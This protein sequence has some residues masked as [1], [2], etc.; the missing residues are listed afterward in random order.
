MEP[1]STSTVVVAAAYTGKKLVDTAQE[2]FLKVSRE[3]A[4]SLGGYLRDKLDERRIYKAIQIGQRAALKLDQAGVSPM[5]LPTSFIRP[6]IESASQV[7]DP[8]LHECWANLLASAA[9]DYR[10][11]H[12]SFLNTLPDFGSGD[13]IVLK[14]IVEEDVRGMYFIRPRMAVDVDD[15]I[16]FNR[17]EHSL[18]VEDETDFVPDRGDADEH[19][20]ILSNLSRLNVVS[21]GP[22][23][24]A[25][26]SYKEKQVV[27]A[28][29]G[30]DAVSIR[31]VF[32]MTFWGK[33]FAKAVMMPPS[34]A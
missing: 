1:V 16:I 6:F 3:P 29:L 21:C 13:A 15:A 9:S 22:S 17:R 19:E 23:Q 14:R 18:R 7:D 5:L 10:S 33:M 27:N 32:E 2:L 26:Y 28:V 8:E 11:R 4:E 30:F 34:A 24:P 12:P 31:Y 25:L 20:F